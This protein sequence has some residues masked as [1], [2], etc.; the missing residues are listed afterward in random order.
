MPIALPVITGLGGASCLLFLGFAK[1]RIPR[2]KRGCDTNNQS[3]PIPGTDGWVD[4]KDADG[5]IVAVYRGKKNVSAVPLSE[6]VDKSKLLMDKNDILIS[7]DPEVLTTYDI[8]FRQSSFDSKP[9]LGRC[10]K[11]HSFKDA[12]L[13]D[14]KPNPKPSVV[15][16]PGEW[17][18]LTYAAVKMQAR[19]F[20]TYIRKS[21]GVTEKQKV[22][23]WSGNSVEWMV[24]DWA[25]SAYNWTSVSVYDTLGPDAASFIV[26]DSGSEVLVCE[27]KTFK[28]VPAILD[29][30]IYMN[31]KGA[32]LKVVV[33]TGKGDAEAKAKIEAKG[34]K[35][36][37]LAEAISEVGSDVVPDTP[38][39]QDDLVTIM[40]TSGTTGMPKGVMLTHKN[41]VATISCI[42][43]SISL[44][45]SATDVHLSYLP[46]AHIFERQICGGM[47][48]VGATIYFASQGAKF[49]L[50][51][52]GIIQPTIFAGVP[53]VYENVRDAVKRKMTGFKKKLFDSALAAKIA[54]LETGCGY[55]PIW[56]TLVFSKTKKALGGRV[57]FCLSGGAPI[58][59]DTLQFVACALG[60]VMQ[61]Y[62]ATETSAASTLSMSFDLAVG[63]VGPP[64]GSSMIRLVDVPDMNYFSGPRDQYTG[65]AKAAFDEGRNK[66]GG[67][68]WIGGSGVSPGYFDPAEHSLVKGLPSNGNSRKT[69]DD[70]FEEDGF[71]WF[72]TGDIGTWADNG[73][74]K[75]VDRRKNMFK[76]A[77]GEY[78]PVEEVEKTYQDAVAFADFVFLPKETKVSYIAL[79]VVVSDSIGQVMKWAKENGVEGSAESVVASDKFKEYMSKELDAAA[80]AKKLQRFMWANKKNLHIE[81]QAPGYQEEWVAGVVC[82]NGHKEQ[83]LTATFKARR[84]QLDQYFAP[85]FPKIYPDR[86]ADHILP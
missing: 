45:I 23:I 28:K 64:M 44:T 46:L 65:K 62:G 77:L 79:C 7:A 30:E 75:I 4:E 51:D 27:D 21:C 70:F 24:A 73:C 80:Q 76:T 81:Y 38:P 48:S 72:K 55:S 18:F 12:K 85:V 53:K 66:S 82:A 49:L 22:A 56:D 69:K 10:V 68:V 3:K 50:V 84:S 25:C 74:L 54:D 6:K 31:N 8:F 14:G 13:K 33:F 11:M 29:D 58:S 20:G 37:G 26:A 5:Q 36:V 2:G 47:L 34:L 63:H 17:E 71:S 32:A 78:I 43:T 40:Y 57:R 39:T 67:E 52:L 59:K 1:K 83:L 42:D 35:V 15:D 86:P 60:P 61:G 19:A 41:I 9:A 16:V